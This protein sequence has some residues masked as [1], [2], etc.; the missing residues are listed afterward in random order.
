[1]ILALLVHITYYLAQNDKY[2]YT[3]LVFERRKGTCL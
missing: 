1:M 3:L 2:V